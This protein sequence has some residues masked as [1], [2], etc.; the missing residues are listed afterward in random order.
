MKDL[1]NRVAAVIPGKWIEVAIQLDISMEEIDAI[2]EDKG[3]VFKRFMAVLNQW[4]RSCRQPFTWGALAT[5]LKSTSVNEF[6]LAEK[7]LQE[8][9]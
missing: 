1:A 4:K 7:L 2:G 5:A 3:S 8:F 9:L 6:K